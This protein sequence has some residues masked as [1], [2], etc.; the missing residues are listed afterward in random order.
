MRAKVSQNRLGWILVIGGAIVALAAVARF[1]T[2]V[3]R[4]P[5]RKDF[6][7]ACAEARSRDVPVFAEFTATW[8]GPCQEMRRTTWA[9]RTVAAAL[10]KCVPVQIDIDAERDLALRYA[11]D[12]VPTLVLMDADGHV[13]RSETGAMSVDEFLKWLEPAG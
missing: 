8:C 12:A 7:A 1:N 9:D 10:T 3:E 5:W 6:A 11:P 13:L 4:V 2:G